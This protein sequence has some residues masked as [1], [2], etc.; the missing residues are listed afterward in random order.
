[1]EIN[2]SGIVGSS[3]ESQSVVWSVGLLNDGSV[4]ESQ[5]GGTAGRSVIPSA[6]RSFCRA[7][8]QLV[9]RCHSISGSVAQV[10]RPVNLSVLQPIRQA[11]RPVVQPVSRSGS[12]A[13]LSVT[14]ARHSGSHRSGSQARQSG[15]QAV[16]Q[17]GSMF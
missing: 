3:V 1:M 14:Q 11:G 10:G 17:V 16:R 4:E 9:G 8:S 15:S 7:V 2:K 12:Q 6:G 13:W 5:N